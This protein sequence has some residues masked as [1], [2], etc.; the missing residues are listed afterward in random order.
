MGE[1][2]LTNLAAIGL[3]LPSPAYLVGSVLFGIVGYL[4]FRRGRQQTRLD[5]TWTGVGLMIYP[6]AVAQT[7]LLWLIGIVVCG[8]LYLKWD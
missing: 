4:A 5:M 1:D 6:Y 3:A 2:G 8:W 7:W